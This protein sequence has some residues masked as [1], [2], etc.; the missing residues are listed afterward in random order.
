MHVT[1]VDLLMVVLALAV[2][3]I[4]SIDLS[5]GLDHGEP[6]CETGGEKRM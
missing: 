6:W 3:K 5:G 4:T 1:Y 2:G